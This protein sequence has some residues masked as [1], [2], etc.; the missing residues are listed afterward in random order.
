MSKRRFPKGLVVDVVLVVFWVAIL[1]ELLLAQ[2]IILAIVA[3]ICVF[4]FS[5][6]LGR[7]IRR[8]RQQ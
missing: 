8:R 7:D 3:F 2:D 1:I 6:L 5:A 4:V